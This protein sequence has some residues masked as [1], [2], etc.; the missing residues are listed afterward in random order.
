MTPYIAAIAVWILIGTALIATVVNGRK[1]PNERPDAAA[2]GIGT[3]TRHR[4]S[5]VDG[6]ER[7]K[8][9]PGV[10]TFFLLVG[11][12]PSCVLWVLI[13]YPPFAGWGDGATVIHQLPAPLIV[14]PYSL[15]FGAGIIASFSGTRVLR[16]RWAQIGH[17]SPVISLL[18]LGRDWWLMLFVIGPSFALLWPAWLS[19]LQQPQEK[20]IHSPKPTPSAVH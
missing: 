9:R 3:T 6:R 13:A 20:P 10:A 11:F 18:S 5:L 8:R 2:A 16:K 14:F 17:L 19:L 15:F 1:N 12:V 7:M 4:T